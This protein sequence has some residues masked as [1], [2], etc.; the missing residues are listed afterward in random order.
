MVAASFVVPSEIGKRIQ[1]IPQATDNRPPPLV[2][3]RR[4]VRNIK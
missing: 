4:I 2:G 3:Y 1:I